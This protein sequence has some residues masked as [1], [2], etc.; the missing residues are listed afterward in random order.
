MGGRGDNGRM[1]WGVSPGMLKAIMLAPVTLACSMAA[2]SVHR[3]LPSSQ[4]PS[5]ASASLLSAV[6]STAN[7]AGVGFGAGVGVGGGGDAVGVGSGV[8]V[9]VGA[10]V[11]V[12][13]G[14]GMLQLGAPSAWKP[15]PRALEGR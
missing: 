11:C 5:F 10:G 9:G 13:V 7:V 2:R 1:V 15:S 14:V 6:E 8:A 12:G 3:P 4:R